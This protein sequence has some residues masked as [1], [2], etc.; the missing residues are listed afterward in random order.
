MITDGVALQV[1]SIKK[2][3]RGEVCGAPAD[4]ARL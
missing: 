4:F 2:S 1:F 3:D